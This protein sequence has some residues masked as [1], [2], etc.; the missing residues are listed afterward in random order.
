MISLIA[1]KQYNLG[2]INGI[3][4]LG[5]PGSDAPSLFAKFLSSAIGLM[6]VIAFIWFLFLLITGA[7]AFMTAGGDKMALE[8]ARKRITTGLIGLVI[9]IAAIFIMDLI[10]TLLGIPAILDVGNWIEKLSPTP[11]I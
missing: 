8:N 2:D 5:T 6:T 11:I 1:Q 9:V 7:I 3:G 4:P 10:A